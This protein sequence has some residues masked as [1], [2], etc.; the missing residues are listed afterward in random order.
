MSDQDYR[1]FSQKY[2]PL[3]PMRNSAQVWPEVTSEEAIAMGK[4]TVPQLM[5]WDIAKSGDS[6]VGVVVHLEGE[7]VKVDSVFSLDD[8]VTVSGSREMERKWFALEECKR[9]LVSLFVQGDYLM[10]SIAGCILRIERERLYEGDVNQDTGLPYVSMS[11]YYP[12][13]LLELKRG[14]ALHKL[15]ERQVRDYVRIRKA[16]I[17][18]LGFDEQKV[19]SLGPSRLTELLE[20]ADYDRVSGVISEEPREGKIGRGQVLDMVER[21]EEDGLD[22]K[23]VRDTLNEVRGVRPQKGLHAAWGMTRGPDGEWLYYLGELTLSEEG[24]MHRAV[25]GGITKEQVLYLNKRMGATSN[26]TE[27]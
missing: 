23:A 22:V 24:S 8:G 9:A 1:P 19:M 14:A 21:I 7:I 3:T 12:H 11:E 4:M 15:G 26:I 5:G 20:A 27:D 6:T 18:Q 13:L 17:E 25:D 16:F 10:L 2:V